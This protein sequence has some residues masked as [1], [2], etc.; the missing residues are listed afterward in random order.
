MKSNT[1]SLIGEAMV[2]ILYPL[3]RI[4]LRNGVTYKAFTEIVKAVY[5]KVAVTD[6]HIP[7][8]K[9]TDSRIAVITGLSRKE[10]KRV[11]ELDISPRPENL[12]RHNRA[13]RV[14]R[15]WQSDKAFCDDSGKPL[16]LTMDGDNGFIRL[17]RTHSGD[18]P[19]RAV[20]DE[21][22]RVGAVTTTRNGMLRLVADD[23]VPPMDD[24]EK[25]RYMGLAAGCLI[26][27]ADRNLSA[28]NKNQ[29]MQ[30]LVTSPYIPINQREQF[31]VLSEKQAG[32][33]IE[34][35]EKWLVEHEDR[36]D[37][38]LSLTQTKRVGVG[39]FYFED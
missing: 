26:A 34:K 16:E 1:H 8:R 28:D 30:R 32:Q 5:V 11:R 7:G 35:L 13:A 17:V 9:Q 22:E 24:A 36:E 10:T 20:L 19:V 12:I 23:Y 6:S 38:A 29:L 33:L 27:T 18:A 3:V 2:R 25:I 37:D 31:R 14:I 39:I 4:C 15:G 21:L